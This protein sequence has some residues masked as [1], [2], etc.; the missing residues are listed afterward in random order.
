MYYIMPSIIGMFFTS[1]TNTSNTS[2][3]FNYVLSSQTVPQ[4][5]IKPSSSQSRFTSRFDMN[6][7]FAARGKRC[8]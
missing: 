7:I 8:G 5:A 3:V 1:N 2:P 6:S 4:S